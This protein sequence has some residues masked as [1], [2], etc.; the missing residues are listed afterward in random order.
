MV[1]RRMEKELGEPA[2][3]G[4]CRDLAIFAA[5]RT[6]LRPITDDDSGSDAEVRLE[7]GERTTQEEEEE[8]DRVLAEEETFGILR[9]VG[10]VVT[11]EERAHNAVPLQIKTNNHKNH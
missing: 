3:A 8:D 1:A 6:D 2:K 9:N 5:G 10:L 4:P 11:K 7:G